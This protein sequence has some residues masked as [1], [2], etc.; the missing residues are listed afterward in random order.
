MC[1]GLEGDRR[2][3]LRLAYVCTSNM[4]E[5]C[6][7]A[8]QL[9]PLRRLSNMALGDGLAEGQI[10]PSRPGARQLLEDFFQGHRFSAIGLFD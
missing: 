2:V 3:M 6:E 8:I 7:G 5:Q 9:P 1:L 10:L 4:H